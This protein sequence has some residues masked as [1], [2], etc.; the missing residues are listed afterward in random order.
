[1]SFAKGHKPGP[2]GG[3]RLQYAPVVGISVLL[4]LAAT[5]FFKGAV[6]PDRGG[7]GPDGSFLPSRPAAEEADGIRQ[8]PRWQLPDE[9]RQKV[10]GAGRGGRAGAELRALF[11]PAHHHHSRGAPGA[12]WR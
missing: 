5:N 8:S 2:S 11:F 4:T 6:P 9:W 1:M 10:G 7:Q 12:L 3:A